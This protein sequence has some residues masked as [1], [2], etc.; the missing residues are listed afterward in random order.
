MKRPKQEEAFL[1]EVRKI[2]NISLACEKT[3]LSRNTIYRWCKED[4]NFKERLDDALKT[5]IESVSDLAE[6]KLIA[7]INN[8]NMRAIEY[9]LD[10]NKNNYARPRPK[11]FWEEILKGNDS[12]TKI[13]IH[14]P[15]TPEEIEKRKAEGQVNETNK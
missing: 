11:S 10:N 12:V 14:T 8:G 5:G 9:W 7:H 6:S 3:D 1:N 2:P 15:E 13:V 4:Q